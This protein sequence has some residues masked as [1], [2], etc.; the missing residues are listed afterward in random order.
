MSCGSLRY[1]PSSLR[2]SA[3]YLRSLGVVMYELTTLKPPF[4]AFNLAGLVAKIK[5]AAL[6]PIPPCYSADWTAILK[7]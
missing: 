4:N 7:R 2:V 3:S 6:P 1:A 5:R